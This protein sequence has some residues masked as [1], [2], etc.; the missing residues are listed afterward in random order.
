MFP[1]K[2]VQC[3]NV[4][5]RNV[6]IRNV[7]IRN[8]TDPLK[9]IVLLLFYFPKILI[10]TKV[11]CKRFKFLP[12]IKGNLSVKSNDKGKNIRI[13]LHIAFLQIIYLNKILLQITFLLSV[14]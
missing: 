11:K 8:V 14:Q 2:S 13:F 1:R 7:T 5:I 12:L 4:T 9:S 6:T 3:E 10:R